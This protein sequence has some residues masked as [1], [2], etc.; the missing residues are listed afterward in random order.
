M[1]TNLID[2]RSAWV[3]ESPAVGII[4]RQSVF[5]PLQTGLLCI[6]SRRTKRAGIR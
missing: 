1:N 6:D 4:D 2:G 5:E 3:I